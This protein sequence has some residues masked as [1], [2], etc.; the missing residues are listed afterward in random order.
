MKK[1]SSAATW[2]SRLSKA[3]PQHAFGPRPQARA[4]QRHPGWEGMRL[5]MRLQA[6]GLLLDLRLESDGSTIGRCLA[7]RAGGFLMEPT[8]S[9]WVRELLDEA[10]EE[11]RSSDHPMN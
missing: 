8:G 5:E 2:F 10:A 4:S 7:M 9:A 3:T 11:W 1:T 6:E